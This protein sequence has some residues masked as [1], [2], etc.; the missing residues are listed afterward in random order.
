[1]YIEIARGGA[2][3]TIRK[4]EERGHFDFG[5]L[6]TRHSFSFGD[7]RDPAHDRFRA[8]RV[9]NEDRVQPGQGFGTHGHKDMEILTWVLSGTLAH[10]DS[11][12]NVGTLEPGDAQRMTAGS[13]IRHSEFNGSQSEVVHFLQIWILPETS[14][15]APDYRQT[16]FPAAERHNRLRLIA[17]RGRQDG[18]LAWN[19]DVALHA[20]LLDPGAAVELPLA[21]GRAGWVQVASGSVEVQG[22]LLQ[23]GDAAALEQ[24][25]MVRIHA[26]TAAELLVFDLA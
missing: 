3:I 16:R 5:W 23:A 25:P 26:I 24:E 13:G 6:D 14:G 17:S 19:Q 1:M 9:L 15:L 22:V 12:G 2:M 4:R 7:Y 8:L 11:S 21:P 10:E 20:T 18:S